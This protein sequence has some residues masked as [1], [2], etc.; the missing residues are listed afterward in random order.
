MLKRLMGL[1]TNSRLLA[2]YMTRDQKAF[3]GNGT[4]NVML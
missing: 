1:S 2:L 4:E 3:A